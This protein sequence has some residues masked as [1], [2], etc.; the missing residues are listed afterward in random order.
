MNL[1]RRERDQKFPGSAFLSN[2]FT[3]NLLFYTLSFS[4]TFKYENDTVYFSQCYPYTYSDL[5]LYLEKIKK[6]D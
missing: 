1:T 2:V 5:K 6:N 4:Y 3:A